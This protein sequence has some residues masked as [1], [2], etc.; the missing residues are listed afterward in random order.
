MIEL[1]IALDEKPPERP[2]ED[3]DTR[4]KLT[5]AGFDLAKPISWEN[6]TA[7]NCRRFAQG[8]GKQ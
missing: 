4:Q 3:H 1:V 8:H 6:K 5:A 7:T 2:L